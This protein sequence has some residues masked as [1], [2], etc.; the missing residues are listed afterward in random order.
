[1][2]RGFAE[3]HEARE[4]TEKVCGWVISLLGSRET[5]LG[6]PKGK[7]GLLALLG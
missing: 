3:K 6:K 5:L 7:P 4:K 1:M 2:P